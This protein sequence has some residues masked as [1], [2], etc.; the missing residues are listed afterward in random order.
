MAEDVGRQVPT[1]N[2]NP[3]A[4]SHE[5]LK[6]MTDAA[7]PGAAQAVA[8][9]WAELADGFDEAVELFQQAM[10][11]SEGGWTGEAADG[12]RTQL[13]RVAR[14][15]KD[16]GASYRAASAA[17]TAQ[18]AAADHAKSTMPQ[19]VPYDPAQLIRDATA[20]GNAV[21]LAMLPF[22]MYEQ[23]Q[24]HDAAHAEAARVVSRRDA[25]FIQSASEIPVFTAPPVL[26]SEGPAAV[27]APAPAA[28]PMVAGAGVAPVVSA[29][30][31][32]GGARPV[33]PV[34]PAGA[35]RIP[36]PAAP[37]DH[38]GTHASAAPAGSFAPAAPS[39]P[40]QSPGAAGFGGTSAS[41][42]SVG[43]VGPAA[44]G[45]FG[46][47]GFG[48]SGGVPAAGFPMAG[49]GAVGP[50]AGAAAPVDKDAEHKRPEYLIEPD[51]E[52]MFGFDGMT[53]PPVIGEG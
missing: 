36:T 38:G 32:S 16:M 37:T 33:A 1:P 2:M 8:D 22:R 3:M 14:W 48:P 46:P 21:E 53:A 45:G 10:L 23:K 31:V 12:M 24:R 35:P 43:P 39:A 40:V 52:G 6:A 27:V 50:V 18:T 11:G 49:H 17:I 7:N 20:S 13:G 51:S 30:M 9:G 44:A 19:P 47:T 42:A 34:H 26:T 4:Q 29:P 28:G 15:S 41:A 5:A 25:S